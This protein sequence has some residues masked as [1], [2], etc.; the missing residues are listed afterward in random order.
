MHNQQ[1]TDNCLTLLLFDFAKVYVLLYTV[2][3]MFNLQ[4][5]ENPLK[6]PGQLSSPNLT[7]LCPQICIKYSQPRKGFILVMAHWIMLAIPYI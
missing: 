6:S 1:K 5:R 2:H 4:L 7:A 3:C